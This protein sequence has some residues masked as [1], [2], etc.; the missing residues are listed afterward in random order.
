MF[1]RHAETE[2]NTRGVTHGKTDD[3]QLTEVGKEQA[4]K[5][6]KI[7]VDGGVTTIYSSPANRAQETAEFIAKDDNLPLHTL[8]E[9]HERDWGGWSG[10]PW[11]D[12]Q[13]VLDPM[14]LDERFNFVPP[15][16]ESWKQMEVRLQ[17]AL[18]HIAATK[19]D[20]VAVVLHGGTLRALMPVLNNHAKDSSFKYE[21]GNASITVYEYQN[22]TWRPIL[23]NDTTHLGGNKASSVISIFNAKGQL[24][25]QLRA[26]DDKK[27]PLHWDF[28]AAGEIDPGENSLEGAKRELKEELGVELDV[29]P[30][31]DIQYK[32]PSDGEHL[33][34][35]K[36]KY[37]GTFKP[38]PAEVAE[39]RF[40]DRE[41]VDE[42]LESGEKFHPQ[43][44]FA[45]EKGLI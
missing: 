36:A 37:D 41:E 12:I 44:S 2:V 1:I 26:S 10:R 43:F 14:S 19:E 16:G 33:Y 3:A 6:A 32:S 4:R 29:E 38:D 31:G 30:T 45:W 25:L 24:A 22:G 39:A 34:F 5:V 8:E 42:M 9:L 27:Y 7:C 20:C 35:F 17:Q 15:G 13:N 18:D 21:F 23:I 11:S 28:S 40:F